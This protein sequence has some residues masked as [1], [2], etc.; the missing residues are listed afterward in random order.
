MIADRLSLIASRFATPIQFSSLLRRFPIP[1]VALVIAVTHAGF[2]LLATGQNSV[3][4]SY[5]SLLEWDAKWYA[6]ILD[7]G[8]ECDLG[9]LSDSYYLCNCAFFPGLPILAWP[10][11][12]LGLPSWLA[13]PLIAQACAWGFWNYLLLLM[14]QWSIQPRRQVIAVLVLLLYP[15]SFFLEVGYSEAPF[16][17]F[18]MGFLY[19]SEQPGRRS[20]WLAALHGVGMTG[21]RLMGVA[22]IGWPLWREWSGRPGNRRSPLAWVWHRRWAIALVVTAS[23]GIVLFYGYLG[24]R[25][26][27][28]DLYHV[29]QQ[30]GMNVRPDY[31]AFLRWDFY[32]PCYTNGIVCPIVLLGGVWLA[33]RSGRLFETGPT[34]PLLAVAG[35]LYYL[36]MAAMID[37]QLC[38][39]PRIGYPSIVL[40]ALAWSKKADSLPPRLDMSPRWRYVSMALLVTPSLICLV[41][42]FYFVQRFIQRLWVA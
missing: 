29:I 20:W 4:A 21:T 10:L 36:A 14:R 2:V 26:G 18:L 6:S 12:A 11:K 31:F 17:M 13:L 16:L 35:S 8:Y 40:L 1:V 25:F 33:W 42:Q 32:V 39:L 27:R 34:W 15:W 22:A 19:W 9:R 5:R 24:W 3:G 28:P 23:L 38:S 37:R 41:L 7:N 30:T